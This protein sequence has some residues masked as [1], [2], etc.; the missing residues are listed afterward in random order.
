MINA[1]Q[2]KGIWNAVGDFITSTGFFPIE[3]NV[4]DTV[5][6]IVSGAQNVYAGISSTIAGV[7]ATVGTIVSGAQNVYT[8]ISSGVSDIGQNVYSG[9]SGIA[10]NVIQRIPLL[11]GVTSSNNPRPLKSFFVLV[12][13]KLQD[14][15]TV[16]VPMNGQANQ[17]SNR[18]G[19]SPTDGVHY[20]DGE[21]AVFIQNLVSNNPERIVQVLN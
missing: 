3:I 20:L 1:N 10:G 5:G 17:L 2:P 13:L 11:Q 18:L 21:Q 4:P 15:N 7:P 16:V 8:G 6:T 14:H 12:P 9:I 19:V